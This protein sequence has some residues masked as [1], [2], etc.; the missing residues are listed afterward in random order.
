VW[1]KR[2][3]MVSFNT[4]NRKRPETIDVDVD[5]DDSDD[6]CDDDDEGTP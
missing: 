6:G 3:R 4:C 5:N 1:Q 2:Y